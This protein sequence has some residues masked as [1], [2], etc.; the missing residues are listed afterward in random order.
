MELGR[1]EQRL[2]DVIGAAVDL[3]SDTAIRPDLRERVLAEAVAL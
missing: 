2:V 3:V 1:L